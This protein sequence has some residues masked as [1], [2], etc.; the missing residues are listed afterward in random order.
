VAF[1]HRFQ[2]A[3]E[4][5]DR[6]NVAIYRSLCSGMPGK[7]LL[8]KL[9]GQGDDRL[10]VC[11]RPREGRYAILCVK[12]KEQYEHEATF[13]TEDE[14]IAA[15]ITLVSVL[16]WHWELDL[17]G[18]CR[19]FYCQQGLPVPFPV[20]V[21]PPPAD[22]QPQADVQSK[23]AEGGVVQ[24]L[25]EKAKAYQAATCTK[26]TKDSDVDKAQRLLASMKTSQRGNPY[27]KLGSRY[28]FVIYR[29]K[30]GGFK[31]CFIADGESTFWDSVYD[32]QLEAALAIVTWK[33]GRKC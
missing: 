33:K 10:V 14:A 24:A 7:G 20:Y 22:P 19:C 15:T 17:D 16:G 27:I 30:H 3:L 31:I 13:E 1:G 4:Q 29:H 9:H 12:G 18:N 2:E 6:E 23:P 21:T 25:K 28:C 26:P 5:A 8:R 32:T 11:I